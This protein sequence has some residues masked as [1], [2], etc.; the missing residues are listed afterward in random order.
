MI[1]AL[2]R[3]AAIALLGAGSLGACVSA[4]AAPRRRP[5][6][7]LE[8][9]VTKAL[10]EDYAGTLRKLAGM[11]YTHLGMS[12]AGNRPGEVFALGPKERAALVREAGMQVG[13]ARYGFA[14]G[15]REQAEQAVEIG[16]SILAYTA[17]PV[18]FRGAKFGQTT[19]AAFDKWLPELGKMA[20]TA[21]E[22]GLT[23][24]YHNHW[25]DFKPL[26]GETP[27]EIIARTYPPSLVGFEIDLAWAWLGGADPF[28]VVSTYGPRVR[29]LHL[30]DVDPSRGKDMIKQLVEPGAGRLDYATLL[31]KLDKITD[32]IGYVEVD[33]PDDGMAAAASA[34]RF[35][36][37]VRAGEA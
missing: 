28:T 12:L 8:M 9:T 10:Q 31:P 29:S 24:V 30:K 36:L 33:Q 5:L 32:A 37:A 16:A 25:W 21:R 18:F 4:S 1:R 26:D 7:V 2:D 13:V 27:L 11:G 19:R 23:L 20:E 6:G 35:L 15:F 34:A 14:G 22:L 3:R 17:A